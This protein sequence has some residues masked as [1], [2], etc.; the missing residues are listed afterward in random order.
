VAETLYLGLAGRRRRR[1]WGSWI[2]M[3][4]WRRL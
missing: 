2:S 1:G 3:M 4:F